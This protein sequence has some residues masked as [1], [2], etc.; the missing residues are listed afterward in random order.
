MDQ[1]F[2]FLSKREI[3]ESL[4]FISQVA[5]LMPDSNDVAQPNQND[6]LYMQES[7]AQ[8]KQWISG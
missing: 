1:W 3:E 7:L 5:D 2:Q 4:P 8:A 6:D